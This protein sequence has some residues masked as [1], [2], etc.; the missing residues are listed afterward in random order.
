ME[1]QVVADLQSAVTCEQRR[2]A[3]HRLDE[4]PSI[5]ALLDRGILSLLI[6]QLTWVV[7]RSSVPEMDAVCRSLHRLTR[8]APNHATVEAL[9]NDDDTVLEL[10]SICLRSGASTV[11][12]AILHTLSGTCHASM[13]M[14]HCRSI[15]YR[16]VEALRTELDPDDRLE[17]LGCL[18]NIT[19]YAEA[20]RKMLLEVPGLILALTELPVADYSDKQLERLSAVLRNLALSP[21]CRLALGQCPSFL[22]LLFRLLSIAH[23]RVMRN[24]LSTLHS[25]ALERDTSLLLL[26]HQDGRLVPILSRLMEDNDAAVRKRATRTVRLLTNDASAPL[27]VHRDDLMHRLSHHALQDI[28]RL[29]R[30]EATEA[31][32]KCAGLVRAQQPQ[33]QAVLEAL[34]QLAQSPGVSA[35]VLARTVKD[36]ASHPDNRVAMV[37]S[38]ELVHLVASLAASE[39]TSVFAKEDACHALSLL[40][41]EDANRPRLATSRVLQGL[42]LNSQGNVREPS[43]RQEYALWT[44]VQ[45]ASH[46]ESRATMVKHDTLLKAL[47]QFATG[48][49]ESELKASVKHAIMLLVADL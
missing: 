26:F 47:I 35:D 24:A 11:P 48:A 7:Q 19:C 49:D 43:S 21:D 20:D 1:D 5:E 42:V 2:V 23:Q 32:A 29:V 15:L 10:L 6:L 31:F 17:L 41:L 8:Q 22:H 40:A 3:L 27:L 13:R 36:Q 33:Y 30:G 38:R 12:L 4:C 44:L 45:L 37:E 25:L 14:V 39:R 16:M 46:G 28:D 18:K 34:L 9:T